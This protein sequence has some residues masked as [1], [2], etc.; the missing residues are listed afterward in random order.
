MKTWNFELWATTLHA[1]T[2]GCGA[3]DAGAAEGF[4]G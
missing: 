2:R 4:R 3:K 1:A